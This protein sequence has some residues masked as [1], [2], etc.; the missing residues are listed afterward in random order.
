MNPRNPMNRSLLTIAI[1]AP[2]LLSTPQVRADVPAAYLNTFKVW[3]DAESALAASL[4]DPNLPPDGTGLPRTDKGGHV[5]DQ[6]HALTNLTFNGKAGD[7][8][9]GG[10]GED[11]VCYHGTETYLSAGIRFCDYVKDV[12]LIAPDA[13]WDTA[14]GLVKVQVSPNE[15]S[16]KLVAQGFNGENVVGFHTID[17]RLSTHGVYMVG[18]HMSSVTLLGSDH[19]D[20]FDT[21]QVGMSAPPH[22][23][24]GAGNDL[25]DYCAPGS[26]IDGGSDYDTVSIMVQTPGTIRDIYVDGNWVIKNVEE[27]DTTALNGK[28][29][30]RLNLTIRENLDHKIYGS[31]QDDTFTVMNNNNDWIQTGGGTDDLHLT[32]TTGIR[33]L[34]FG[35]TFT[36][37]EMLL[38]KEINHGKPSIA[39]DDHGVLVVSGFKIDKDVLSF[40][41]STKRHY[42]EDVTDL[43]TIEETWRGY[44][45]H[46]RTS[47]NDTAAGWTLTINNGDLLLSLYNGGGVAVQT[48]RFVQQGKTALLDKL[49]YRLANEFQWA[50]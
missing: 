20:I 9:I 40:T 30:G 10:L 6:S 2:L 18:T 32:T 31:H 14:D 46:E 37:V 45:N 41:G 1:A 21:N 23:V 38:G 36:A 27:I 44:A 48:I 15:D 42:L 34:Y 13:K 19:G 33:T 22:M 4:A 35:N 47:A 49:R 50:S 17:A 3:L 29:W 7:V 39:A 43:H 28:N 16:K 25:F 24:G 11:T 12:L 5:Y 8:F 26:T